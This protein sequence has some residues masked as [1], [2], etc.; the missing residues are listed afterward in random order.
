[1]SDGDWDRVAERFMEA[2]LG[3][4]ATLDELPEQEAT[5]LAGQFLLDLYPAHVLAAGAAML[6]VRMHRGG[7]R[8]APVTAGGG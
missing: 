2:T 1:M 3:A 8:G 6:A 7:E 4:V 5:R